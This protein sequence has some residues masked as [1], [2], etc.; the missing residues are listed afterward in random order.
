MFVSGVVIYLN[1]VSGEKKGVLTFS[2]G[3]VFITSVDPPFQEST[4]QG[5][6]IGLNLS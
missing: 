1:G 3:F 5:L 2:Y 6:I 4:D